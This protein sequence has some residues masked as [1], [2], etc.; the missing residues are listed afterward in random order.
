MPHNCSGY[1]PSN[2]KIAG[3]IDINLDRSL[4]SFVGEHHPQL[5]RK[6]FS[7]KESSN[8]IMNQ[9]TNIQRFLINNGKIALS[10]D[11]NGLSNSYRKFRLL[12]LKQI[13]IVI[14]SEHCNSSK[15]FISNLKAY[16]C[17]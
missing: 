16:F 10:Q 17:N 9:N 8:F 12:T 2:H 6:L 11:L 1:T 4:N 5:K 7:N 13:Y 3:E 15:Y 14:G